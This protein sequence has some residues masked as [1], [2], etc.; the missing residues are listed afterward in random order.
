MART[1]V[2]DLLGGK[3]ALGTEV[4]IQGWVR[5]RRDSKAGMSFLVVHDGSAFD[6][7]QA[8]VP[9]TLDNY[10]EEVQK[11]TTG[12]SVEVTGNLIESQGKGQSVELDATNVTVVGW[13]EDPE[14][15]P[16]QQKRHSFEY[17]REQA[18]LRARTNTF[19]AMARVRNCLAQA[20]HRYFHNRGF[21]WV[22]T[23]IVTASDCEGAGELFRVSTLDALNPARTK[24]GKVDFSQDFFGK[25]SYLTVSGQLNVETYA[26]ALNDVYT[27]GPTF[28]A[29]NS[30]TSR[31]L[32]EFWICLLYTSPSPRD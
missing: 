14:T 5:S 15:Y 25:E 11:L 9:N 10:A 26:C 4:T 13:V 18:H 21:L 32:A 30:N 6:A 3:V 29:E 19:G 22:H 8:V 24:E 20:V 23:P 16:M 1:K 27:F 12:C 17:L 28:R 7:L 2:C 31:H